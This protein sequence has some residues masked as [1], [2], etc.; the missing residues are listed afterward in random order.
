MPRRI[1][2]GIV[3]AHHHGDVG[4]LGRRADDH[5]PRS[6]VQ[7]QRRLGPFGVAA[8]RLDDHLHPQLP[9]GQESDVGRGQDPYGLSLEDQTVFGMPYLVRPDPMDAVV[10]EKVGEGS[11]IG[12]VVDRDH[13]E[14]G[15]PFCDGS[16]DQSAY[17]A[18]T[19]YGDLSAHR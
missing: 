17:P 1:V 6:L 2:V 19:V 18:E 9:P 14:I 13:L 10:F 11:G 12:D 8:G 15:S 4:V 3:D 7:V 16:E 5:L